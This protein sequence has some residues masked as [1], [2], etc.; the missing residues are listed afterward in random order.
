MVSF[1]CEKYIHWESAQRRISEAEFKQYSMF[2]SFKWEALL[3]STN[4]HCDLKQSMLYPQIAFSWSPK[5]SRTASNFLIHSGGF[6]PIN[7]ASD[8]SRGTHS[9]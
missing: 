4:A 9:F 8:I 1:D 6:N 3:C 2:I 5:Y 7:V